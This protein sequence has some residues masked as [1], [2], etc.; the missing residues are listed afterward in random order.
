[1]FGTPRRVLKLTKEQQRLLGA[2]KNIMDI[3][4]KRYCSALKHYEDILMEVHKQHCPDSAVIDKENGLLTTRTLVD[5]YLV[6]S[7]Y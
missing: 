3:A 7:R 6:I 1:M 2:N 4:W 5:N